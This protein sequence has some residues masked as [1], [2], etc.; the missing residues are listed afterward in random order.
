M[1]KMKAKTM[2][3]S[4][5]SVLGRIESLQKRV[6]KGDLSLNDSV[7][8]A[9]EREFDDE[10]YQI[11]LNL[12]PW[13]KGPFR[14]NELFID[15]EWQSFVKFNLLKPHL[16]ELC[17]KVV[18]DVGCNN[19]YYLFKMLEFAPKKLV[20][21]DPSVRTFLQFRLINALAKTSVKYE[22]L[23]VESLPSYEHKFDIIFCLG[24][25]YHRSDPLKMLKELKASL[26]KGGVVFLDTLY[27]ADER[28]IALVPRQTYSKIA[29]IHFVPSISA[30]RNWCE[31]AG[32]KGFKVLAT[33]ATDSF[34]QRKT[35]WSEGFSLSDFLD[36]DDERLTCEGY[37]APQRVYVRL[38]L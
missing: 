14:I 6:K 26:N 11:A 31:R 25:I 35:A 9:C 22:L 7:E 19:G 4:E 34:E 33:R 21:F 20:G 24:V 28:E 30:L 10:I 27:I 1:S 29:N 15:S 37:P 32:F 16:N 2:N 5:K 23:G 8:I 13:R 38:E 36:K 18:A 17:G 3:E 12:K